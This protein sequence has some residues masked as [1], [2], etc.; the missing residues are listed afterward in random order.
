MHRLKYFILC[1]SFINHCI[2]WGV[3]SQN[4]LAQLREPTGKILRDIEREFIS[5]DIF[6]DKF[7]DEAMKFV[8]SGEMLGLKRIILYII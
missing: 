7:T 3:M 1:S 4:R 6:T 2:V 5:F 8:G